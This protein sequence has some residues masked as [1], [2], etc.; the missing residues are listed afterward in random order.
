MGIWRA[1]LGY[2]I[3]HRVSKSLY[4]DTTHVGKRVRK[5]MIIRRNDEEEEEEERRR[6]KRGERAVKGGC[7]GMG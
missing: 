5:K 4:I 2:G 7:D 6:E 3:P 1:Q